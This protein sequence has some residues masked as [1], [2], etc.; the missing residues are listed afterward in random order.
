MKKQNNILLAQKYIFNKDLGDN[1]F[2]AVPNIVG[3]SIMVVK[4]NNQ[5]SLLMPHAT[6]TKDKKEI[7]VV[8]DKDF[9]NKME[10]DQLG[11]SRESICFR[12]GKKECHFQDLEP[13]VKEIYEFF[14]DEIVFQGKIYYDEHLK[15]FRFYIYDILMYKEYDDKRG[16]TL[17]KDRRFI[18]NMLYQHHSFETMD[19]PIAFYYGKDIKE[20]DELFDTMETIYNNLDGYLIYKENGLYT[21]GQT[22]EVLIKFRGD[23]V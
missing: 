21:F 16:T 5:T 23:D 22:T 3:R 20:C 19:I 8:V 9:L 13:I 2:Y 4:H 18:L 14:M 17:Y 6:M 10:N 12:V 1:N 11:V 15:K 7:S